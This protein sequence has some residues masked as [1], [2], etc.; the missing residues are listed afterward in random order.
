MVE[1][2]RQLQIAQAKY[3]EVKSEMKIVYEE[4]LTEQLQK[5]RNELETCHK[6]EVERFTQLLYNARL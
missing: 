5:L 2:R 1:I 3:F 4:M 6:S